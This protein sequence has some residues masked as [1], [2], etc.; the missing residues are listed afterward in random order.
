[1]TE[2]HEHNHA[3]CSTDGPAHGGLELGPEIA[4]SVAAAVEKSLRQTGTFFEVV[5]AT[6]C[7]RQFK[8][9]GCHVIFYPVGDEVE[10]CIILPE[11]FDLPAR[12]IKGKSQGWVA[13]LLRR[14]V[15]RLRRRVS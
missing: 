2:R 8:A 6:V 7:W 5:F 12:A 3:E 13:A 14:T 15:P 4:A 1:M 9:M 10:I 11:G